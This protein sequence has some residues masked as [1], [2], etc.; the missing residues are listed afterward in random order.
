MKTDSENETTEIRSAGLL[1]AV[2]V[3]G[4]RWPPAS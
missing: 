1:A 2:V 3:S 4:E